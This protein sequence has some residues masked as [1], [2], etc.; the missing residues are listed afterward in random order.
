MDALVLAYWTS[1]R[2]L[3]LSL[4]LT[5]RLLPYNGHLGVICMMWKNCM[6]SHMKS[7]EKSYVKIYGHCS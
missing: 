4:R 3:H 1:P 2:T 5:V 7:Y 6:K